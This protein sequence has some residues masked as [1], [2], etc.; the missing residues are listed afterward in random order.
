M[1]Y[2]HNRSTTFI[3]PLFEHLLKLKHFN[4]L[5]STYIIFKD[6]K[7]G[8]YFHILYKFEADHTED[9]FM[10]Y[11]AELTKNEHF[12]SKEDVEGG[13]V[14]FT[15]LIPNALGFTVNLFLKGKYSQY[16]PH[17]KDL[18]LQFWKKVYGNS[19]TSKL[20]K[21]FNK[22]EDLRKELERE[23]DGEIPKGAELASIWNEELEHIT[24]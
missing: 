14:L 23:Y 13:H 12:I 9:G 21:I 18:I 17:Y 15:F 2:T 10:S 7:P 20:S 8:M 5:E 16:P 11:E 4:L 22:S 19:G 6:Y 1:I 24:I 3:Y